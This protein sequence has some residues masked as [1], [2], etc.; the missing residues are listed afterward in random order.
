MI[1]E[2]DPFASDDDGPK[3]VD[4][5]PRNLRIAQAL[6]PAL[7]PF[8]A[9][10]AR[11]MKWVEQPAIHILAT[12]CFDT[13]FYNAKTINGAPDLFT[14]AFLACG[15]AHEIMHV[16]RMD[17]EFMHGR[18]P[19][20]ANI[21]LDAV[22]NRD[23]L[24]AGW[25]FPGADF[26]DPIRSYTRTGKKICLIATSDSKAT[27]P[28]IYNFLAKPSAM[29]DRARLDRENTM[30]DGVGQP[31][32]PKPDQEE[33][34]PADADERRRE[35]TDRARQAISEADALQRILKRAERE[36]AAEEAA[37]REAARKAAQPEPAKPQPQASPADD[38]DSDPF[39]ADEGADESSDPFD[40]D[41]GDEG[42]E[43]EG[44]GDEGEAGDEKGEGEPGKGASGAEGD[45][46]GAMGGASDDEGEGDATSGMDIEGAI[47][48]GM[49]DGANEGDPSNGW[50]IGQSAAAGALEKLGL[51]VSAPRIRLERALGARVQG[52]M[53]GWHKRTRSFQTPHAMSPKFGRIMPGPRQQRVYE[54]AI[55]IDCSGSI[56][57][58]DLQL[59][60]ALAHAWSIKFARQA[61]IHMCFFNDRVVREGTSDTFAN[62][63]NIPNP[64]GGTDF[65]PVF[66]AWLDSLPRYPTHVLHF[67]DLMGAWPDEP[68]CRVVHLVP[69]AY[70]DVKHPFGEIIV[71]EE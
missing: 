69:P 46:G 58:E 48:A 3:R 12:N 65:R 19:Q 28:Y 54:I 11:S 62:E 17:S 50:S 13:F 40:A 55:A 56:S 53:K 64:S 30:K 63:S 15:I 9:C 68:D 33:S 26:A 71:I 14:P 43:G 5:M 44:Q 21:A 36:K 16:L 59:F 52:I 49:D 67:S 4:P 34:A 37:A 60:S 31:D 27:A 61:N 7:D 70:R 51:I 25:K 10:F 24:A 6:L 18:N 32:E 42:D 41:E 38:A 1:D 45:E 20:A 47:G 39:A 57:I 2:F 29:M 22:I 35:I 66:G 23:L 8:M